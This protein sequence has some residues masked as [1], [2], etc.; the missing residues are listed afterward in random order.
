M[1]CYKLSVVFVKSHTAEQLA[2]YHGNPIEKG[3]LKYKVTITVARDGAD[4]L[5]SVSTGPHFRRVVTARL[6]CFKEPGD[7]I[8]VHTPIL[9]DFYN[10]CRIIPELLFSYMEECDHVP[11]YH[12]GYG[13]V[14][15][16]IP[17]ISA[18]KLPSAFMRSLVPIEHR[19]P[20][21]GHHKTRS[22][23]VECHSN[24]ELPTA[25]AKLAIEG[26][27]RIIEIP[28]NGVLRNCTISIET[29]DFPEHIIT[30]DMIIDLI[31]CYMTGNRC[32]N[33]VV[34]EAGLIYRGVA[35][36]ISIRAPNHGR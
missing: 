3:S 28:N 4:F 18:F 35:T 21:T 26:A 8:F 24:P 32:R 34:T 16:L 10:H 22:M 36:T 2:W 15:D 33:I 14:L 9:T 27:S 31:D 20:G 12:P 13:L 1:A 17:H 23:L 5:V 19:I 7:H 11:A 6:R 30:G 29:E 25:L